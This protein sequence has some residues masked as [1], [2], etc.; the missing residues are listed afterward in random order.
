MYVCMYVCMYV[1][2]VKPKVIHTY[3]KFGEFWNLVFT[4][5]FY[6]GSKGERVQRYRKRL[7][8]A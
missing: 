6:S 3:A 2:T 7:K 1:Y 8:E 5:A 4:K